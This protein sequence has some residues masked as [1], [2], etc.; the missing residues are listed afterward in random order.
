MRI[1]EDLVTSLLADFVLEIGS[2]K[3]HKVISCCMANFW[4]Y[5]SL[6]PELYNQKRYL[7]H[8]GVLSEEESFFHQGQKHTLSNF[9]RGICP[10]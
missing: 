3:L 9:M 6:V 10:S 2:V 1:R 7:P 5:V 8:Y 4:Q